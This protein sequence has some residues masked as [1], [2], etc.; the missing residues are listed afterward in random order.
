MH[1]LGWSSAEPLAWEQYTLVEERTKD[2]AADDERLVERMKSYVTRSRVGSA[3]H[4]EV[5]LMVQQMLICSAVR[6]H[7]LQ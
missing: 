7:S 6:R 1:Q 4:T 5:R 3:R 2:K